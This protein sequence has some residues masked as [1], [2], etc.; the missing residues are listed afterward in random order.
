M[1]PP[2]QRP[3]YRGKVTGQATSMD[4]GVVSFTG[5]QIGDVKMGDS[6]AG[7]IHHHQGADFDTVMAFLRSY[8]FDTD[9]RRET[10]LKALQAR[11]DEVEAK[12]A[13]G[14]KWRRD[15]QRILSDALAVIRQQ[16]LDTRE[17]LEHLVIE[18]DADKLQRI[19]RQEETNAQREA[20][21]ERL[22]RLL[23]AETARDAAQATRT[24]RWRI[25][26]RVLVVIGI[27]ALV[28][29]LATRAM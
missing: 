21:M 5:A 13:N 23:A 15:E 9:Q 12:I 1:R 27:F 26:W 14:E 6:A 20:I 16:A 8:T 4:S 7:D 2:R 22:D 28:A 11:L 17:R 3:R 25:A 29:A 19:E 10:V 24:R 18:S